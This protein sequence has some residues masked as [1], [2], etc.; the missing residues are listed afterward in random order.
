[1]WPVASLRALHPGHESDHGHT[2]AN[3]APAG[4]RRGRALMS[5]LVS[6]AQAKNHLRISDAANNTDLTLK[7]SQA[8]AIVLNYL[9]GRYIT[10][11]EITN[12]GGVA[13]VT[14][15]ELHGL[16]TNDVVASGESF[17]PPH[18]AAVVLCCETLEHAACA[19]AICR[20]AYRML[21]PGGVFVVTAAGEGRDPHSAVDGGP[22]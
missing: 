11:S 22:L 20:N 2:G 15:S 16:T 7:I 18:P 8:S 17:Q 19:E 21:A 6:L 5:V 3:G 13:T 12:S 1:M 4:A 14:T 10:V 9:K